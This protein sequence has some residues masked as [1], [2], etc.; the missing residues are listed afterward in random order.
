[1]VVKMLV[2][3]PAGG[4]GHRSLHGGVCRASSSA[5]AHSSAALTAPQAGAAARSCSA[6]DCNRR[7]S[8]SSP[9]SSANG[10]VQTA[11]VMST[12]CS[13]GLP[14]RW[15]GTCRAQHSPPGWHS[16]WAPGAARRSA[17]QHCP[18]R[19]CPAAAPQPRW[20]LSGWSTAARSACT[21]PGACTAAL[22]THSPLQAAVVQSDSQMQ[23][24]PS[25]QVAGPPSNP[26]AAQSQ[27]ALCSWRRSAIAARVRCRAP[28][29]P[30]CC[31]GPQDTGHRAREQQA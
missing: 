29:F 6:P 12:A 15:A 13:S 26:V 14:G 31:K 2:S 18:G 19:S 20:K 30:P 3:G 16:R 1:M 9:A 11:W 21:L 8:L 5:R 7:G 25:M 27:A 22:L 24:R 10:R 28:A 4:L 17:R 23:T